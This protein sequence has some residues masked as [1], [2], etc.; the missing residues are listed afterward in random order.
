MITYLGRPGPTLLAGLGQTCFDVV[1]DRSYIRGREGWMPYVGGTRLLDAR[2]LRL[3]KLNLLR[4]GHRDWS[5]IK[6]TMLAW[7]GRSGW[8]PEWEWAR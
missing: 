6:Y 3:V 7:K 5:S 1:G 2:G 4:D 8:R